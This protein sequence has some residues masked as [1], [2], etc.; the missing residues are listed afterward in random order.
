MRSSVIALLTIL[1][2]GTLPQTDAKPRSSELSSDGVKAT[3]SATGEAPTANSPVVKITGSLSAAAVATGGRVSGF[4][5]VANESGQPVSQLQILAR[6]PEGFSFLGARVEQDPPVAIQCSASQG[7]ASS[8]KC[9][10]PGVLQ[11]QVERAVTLEWKADSDQPEQS[12]SVTVE[13]VIGSANSGSSRSLSLGQISTEEAWKLWVARD[14]LVLPLITGVLGG[15]IVALVQ[16]WLASREKR[17]EDDRAKLAKVAEEDR[18]KKAKVEEESRAATARKLEEE[19]AHKA[20]TWDMMLQQAHQLAMQ[21]YVHIQSFVRGAI[22]SLD[23]YDKASKPGAP[24]D[25]ELSE[26][27][28]RAFLCLLLFARRVQYSTDTV[29]GLYFKNR[30]GEEIIARS[31]YTYRKLYF[32]TSIQTRSE[33][34]RILRRVPPKARVSELYEKMQLSAKSTSA[35][36]DPDDAAAIELGKALEAALAEFEQL[37]VKSDALRTK[38]LPILKGFAAVMQF[39]M[40]RPY[41]YWYNKSSVLE[42]SGLARTAIETLGEKEPFGTDESWTNFRRA[43]KLYLDE[44]TTLGTEDSV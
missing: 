12:M 4:V 22:S 14:P 24:A 3:K 42:I 19:R 41:R 16:A 39:E 8:V 2:F 32:D 34:E 7:M 18:A 1:S 10:I 30:V 36:T 25:P 27:P 6:V 17:A 21:H 31:Y 26:L 23:R 28:V 15:L 11:D 5:T 20:A 29:G 43:A 35:S 13:W 37:W 9:E 44:A 38:L 40:N 33:Y